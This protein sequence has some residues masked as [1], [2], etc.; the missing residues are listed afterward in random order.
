MQLRGFAPNTKAKEYSEHFSGVVYIECPEPC[1]AVALTN[2]ILY[3][4]HARDG[5]SIHQDQNKKNKREF[6]V[7]LREILAIHPNPTEFDDLKEI[8]KHL[9]QHHIIVA[10]VTKTGIHVNHA[11]RSNNIGNRK[12]LRYVSCLHSSFLNYFKFQT[13]A[14]QLTLVSLQE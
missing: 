8:Q 1:L 3:D 2:S 5:G 4:K 9:P 7:K 11:R 12:I 10:R 13:C 6:R 14:S